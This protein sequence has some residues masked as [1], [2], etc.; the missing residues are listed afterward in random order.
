MA[1]IVIGIAVPAAAEDDEPLYRF[2]SGQWSGEAHANADTG[3][4]A[5]CAVKADYRGGTTLSFGISRGNE[6]FLGLRNAEWRLRKSSTF[7]VELMVDDRSFGHFEGQA[8]DEDLALVVFG[9]DAALLEELRRGRR[10]IVRTVRTDLVYELTGTYR[11]LGRLGDCVEEARAL[12]DGRRDPFSDPDRAPAEEAVEMPAT[13]TQPP[14]PPDPALDE[15]GKRFFITTV[16]EKAGYDGV[17]FLAGDDPERIPQAELTWHVRGLIGFALRTSTGGATPGEAMSSA[18]ALFG[19]SCAGDF[20]SAARG[21]RAAGGYR[22]K[23]GYAICRSDD[24]SLSFHMLGL[25]RDSEVLYITHV[26]GN[27]NGQVALDLTSGMEGALFDL[28]NDR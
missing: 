26:A 3:A 8:L 11:A 14:P 22:V 18:L 19:G 9:D 23:E 24:G 21:G 1:A 15:A 7:A 5:Y 17:E 6:L 28:L 12:T 4:F 2:R 25:Y 20:A 16:I 27:G 10:L 13:P